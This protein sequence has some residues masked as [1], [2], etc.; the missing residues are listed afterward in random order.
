[1]STNQPKP[2][3]WRAMLA[4][5][6]MMLMLALGA[7]AAD[8]PKGADALLLDLASDSF[9]K[10]KV[11]I[12]ALAHSGDMR[13]VGFFDA[14]NQSQV[15]LYN[16]QVVLKGER[17]G[18]K[19]EVLSPLDRK[20]LGLAAIKDVKDIDVGNRER[21]LVREAVIMLRLSDSDRERRLMAV[22]KAG[23]SGAQAD[24]PI[25]EE[26]QKTEKDKRIRRAIEESVAL[27]HL[28]DEDAK[29]NVPAAK[30][31]GEIGSGRAMSRLREL[32]RASKDPAAS[33]TYAAAI[34]QI[35]KWER[36]VDWTGYIFSG[37]SLGSVLILI[38][39]GLSIIFGQ[40]NVIN[41]AHGELVMIGA[42][43]TY[44]VQLQFQN[45]FPG[46]FNWYFA[47]AIPVAF[48]AA[49]L[50]GMVIEVLVIRRLYGRPLE[51]LLATFGVGLVLVQLIRLRYGDNIGVNAPT[52][53]QGGVEVAQDIVLPYARLFVLAFCAACIGL[54]YVIIHWT[55]LGLLL[56]AT[57]QN[58]AMAQSLGVPTK[59]VDLFTFALGAGLAGLA[60][61]ALTPIAGVTPDMGSNYIIDAFLVV[62]TGGVGKLAGAIWAGLGMGVSNKLLEPVFAAVW[63]K[64]LILLF[65]ILFIQWKPSG[66]FPAKG[67]LEDA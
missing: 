46:A 9:P 37:L 57:T 35:E 48:I 56:R 23:D 12:E 44:W 22:V 51:T 8:S 41:M 42:Y 55:K 52:W 17:Q 54:M 3:P 34:H 39:L 10:H 18:D 67:R 25:L 27:I 15:Y 7:W 21:R 53:L 6:G 32:S 63:A 49:A 45:Y 29:V 13:L 1:M 36:V 26:M 58:R 19:V 43:A 33:A 20:P 24:L 31:L 61:C 38:A 16:G 40:M 2:G 47:F 62:V 60:G 65:V 66:L 64:V 50:V 30:K 14:Y 59:R 11:A 28:G 4:G 5:I